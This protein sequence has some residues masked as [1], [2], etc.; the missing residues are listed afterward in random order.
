[1]RKLDKEPERGAPGNCTRPYG[2]T[3]TKTTRPWE[4]P[5][6]T[7]H[8]H[9]TSAYLQQE[10]RLNNTEKSKLDT[11]LGEESAR[12]IRKEK[13]NDPMKRP[14]LAKTTTQKATYLDERR[15]SPRRK[16]RSEERRVGQLRT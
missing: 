16:S 12:Q 1:M 9:T 5:N 11:G 4:S 10:R 8:H 2:K 7:T 13:G 14:Q 6:T 15:Q 3:T